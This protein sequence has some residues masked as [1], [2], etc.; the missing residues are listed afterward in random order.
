MSGFCPEVERGKVA[1]LMSHADFAE[2]PDCLFPSIRFDSRPKS[3]FNVP[4]WLM[5]IRVERPGPFR[6][7]ECVRRRS[8]SLT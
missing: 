3:F 5:H 1:K 8:Q 4:A 2:Q 6:V 7:A